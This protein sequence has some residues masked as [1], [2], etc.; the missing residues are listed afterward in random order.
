MIAY[1]IKF[2]LCSGFLYSFYKVF[3]E[4]ESMYKI[5]RFYLLLALI[6]ALIAPLYKIELPITET[7]AQLSPELIAYLLANPQLL[8]QETGFTW[9][10]ALDWIYTI[11]GVGLAIRFILNIASISYRIKQD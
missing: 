5:N 11:V 10:D 9:I 8:Q 7:Q 6:F 1:I 2:V 4:R 3:L